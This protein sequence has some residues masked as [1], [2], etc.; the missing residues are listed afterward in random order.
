MFG[1][2]M[3]ALRALSADA[4]AKLAADQPLTIVTPMPLEPQERER[5]GKAVVEELGLSSPPAASVDPDMI[6]G[7]ELRGQHMRVTNSWRA[8]LDRMLAALRENGNGRHA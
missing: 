7:F 8:D 6:A 1:V 5:Y 3:D 4:R 2:L